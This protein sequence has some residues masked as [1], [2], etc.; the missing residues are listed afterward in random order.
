[1]NIFKKYKIRVSKNYKLNSKRLLYFLLRKFFFSFFGVIFFP[2]LSFSNNRPGQK[3]IIILGRGQ[4]TNFFYKNH[5]KF[6]N[7]KIFF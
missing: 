7:I 4:S 6:K 3:K 5:E 1:M 2:F